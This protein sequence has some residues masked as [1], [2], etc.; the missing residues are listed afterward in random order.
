MKCND[1]RSLMVRLMC[2][3]GFW[4]EGKG[5]GRRGKSE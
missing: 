1:A 2:G 5:N 3:L 4:R